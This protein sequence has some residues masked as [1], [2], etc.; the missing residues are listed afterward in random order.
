MANALLRAHP[1]LSI[2]VEPAKTATTTVFRVPHRLTF[3]TDAR[4]IN[5]PTMV[6]VSKLVLQAHSQFHKE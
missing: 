2:Q 6:S 1:T 5:I 4:T 3:A